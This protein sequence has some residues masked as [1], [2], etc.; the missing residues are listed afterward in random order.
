MIWS[1]VAAG[2]YAGTNW[3]TIVILAKFGG[4]ELVGE[5]ALALAIV[6]PTFMLCGLQLRQLLTTDV[7]NEFEFCDYLGLRILT[8]VAATFVISILL[9]YHAYDIIEI[10]LVITFGKAIEWVSDILFGFFNKNHRIDLI[11][12]SQFIK[13]LLGMI[14][15][16]LVFK[17]T[18]SLFLALAIFGFTNLLVAFY[19]DLKNLKI[20]AGAKQERYFPRYVKD[21][22]CKLVLVALPLGIVMFLISLNSCVPRYLVGELAGKKELGLFAGIY[23][24]LNV[25]SL[26]LNAILQPLSPRLAESYRDNNKQRFIRLTIFSSACGAL[27]WL[28]ISIL[29]YMCGADLFTFLLGPEF[30]KSTELTTWLSIGLGLQ[31]I[32]PFGVQL[33]AM[34]CR[35]PQLPAQ[36][37]TTLSTTMATLVCLNAFGLVGV[38]YGICIGNIVRLSVLSFLLVH[39]LQI[40]F[41]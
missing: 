38:A 21:T 5:Y 36:L 12:K 33:T 3:L 6:S 35:R 17:S 40:G 24:I 14:S 25:V 16:V 34:K 10:G 18:G 39:H 20:L 29:I 30:G 1:F 9:M 13:G 41:E 11:A 19:Y 37:A 7:S 8:V 23:A 22:A 26:P 28:I 31:Y 4:A 27:L 32:S 2:S 15:L